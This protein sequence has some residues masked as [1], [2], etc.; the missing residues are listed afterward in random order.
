MGENGHVRQREWT[1]ALAVLVNE[2]TGRERYRRRQL[3]VRRARTETQD[4]PRPLEFDESRFP[5]AQRISKLRYPRSAAAE[6]Q[7]A[8]PSFGGQGHGWAAG[9]PQSAAA[10]PGRTPNGPTSCPARRTRCCFRV[11]QESRASSTHFDSGASRTRTG[12]LLGAMRDRDC[13]SEV[14]CSP[15]ESGSV[16]VCVALRRPPR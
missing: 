14:A 10:S 9:S 5:I 16:R 7:L 6:P 4:R 1:D 12:G 8:T 15:L 3:Q 13:P 2:Q 11:K